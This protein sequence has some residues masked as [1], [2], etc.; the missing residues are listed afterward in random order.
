MCLEPVLSK[1]APGDRRF[2]LLPG[3]DHPFCLGC[4]RSWRQKTDSAADVDTV[5][6]P[7]VAR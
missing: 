2:G 4:I 6:G 1:A 5:S 7:S 3:C